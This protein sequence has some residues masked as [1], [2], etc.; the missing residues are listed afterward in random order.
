MKLVGTSIQKMI[1]A[2][3]TDL[4]MNFSILEALN[5]SC[6]SKTDN[7]IMVD[8]VA[9]TII[10]AQKKLAKIVV[11]NNRLHKR[12]HHLAKINWNHS[13]QIIVS[14]Q[15]ILDHAVHLNQDIITIVNAAFVMYS[16]M[17]DAMVIKITSVQ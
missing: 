2:G 4:K 1:D 3:K 5:N 13:E 7:F 6:N 16:V 9:M 8:A 10:S 17:V 11:N 14:C 15:L 12:H